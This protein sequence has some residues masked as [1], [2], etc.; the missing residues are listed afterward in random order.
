MKGDT[1]MTPAARACSEL[2][3]ASVADGSGAIMRQNNPFMI[4]VCW[5]S[6]AE[7]VVALLWRSPGIRSC[8][9]W[10]LRAETSH[11]GVLFSA[12]GVQ[13]IFFNL[14]WT[15]VPP[16]ASAPSF[17]L[18][19]FAQSFYILAPLL[20]CLPKRSDSVT[21]FIQYFCQSLYFPFTSTHSLVSAPLFHAE[22][23]LIW[24]SHFQC[25]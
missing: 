19:L 1:S 17:S 15:E 3:A 25:R 11:V 13:D 6:W 10:C 9:C 2:W 23:I 16:K 22:H 8:A 5:K 7:N 18:I 4:S 24:T 12:Y 20:P 14:R 21:N